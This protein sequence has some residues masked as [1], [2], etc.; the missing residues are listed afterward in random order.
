MELS[1]RKRFA[2]CELAAYEE[3]AATCAQNCNQACEV[4][5]QLS[6]SVKKDITARKRQVLIDR[7]FGTSSKLVFTSNYIFDKI[8]S[9]KYY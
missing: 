5:E 1:W 4:Q 7:A 2:I 6:V 8:I 9:I 3:S